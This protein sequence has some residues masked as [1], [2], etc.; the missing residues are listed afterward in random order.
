MVVFFNEFANCGPTAD[1]KDVVLHIEYIR[2]LIGVDF[3]GLGSDFD[4]VDRLSYFNL[5]F[6][7]QFV[8]TITF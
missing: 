6:K 3:I 7:L 4:G 5:L 2:K 1:I 8:I